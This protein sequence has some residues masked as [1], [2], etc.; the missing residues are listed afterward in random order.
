MGFLAQAASVRACLSTLSSKAIG[1]NLRSSFCFLRRWYVRSIQ[2][3]IRSL[4]LRQLDIGLMV[5]TGQQRGEG[6]AAAHRDLL[7]QVIVELRLRGQ[8]PITFTL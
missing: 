3:T 7:S 8:D 2:I 6:P 4:S 1:V 5:L